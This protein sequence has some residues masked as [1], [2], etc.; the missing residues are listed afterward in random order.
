MDEFQNEIR[1]QDLPQTFRDAIDVVRWFPIR[2]LW[3]DSLHSAVWGRKP[4]GLAIPRFY[5]GS[6]LL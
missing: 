2:Y 4:R 5:Y 1:F 3:I 6:H